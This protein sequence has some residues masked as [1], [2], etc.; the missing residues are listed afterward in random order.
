MTVDTVVATR[1]KRRWGARSFA[2]L[3]IFLIAALLTPIALVGHWGHRTVVDSERYIDT[4][5]PL[6]SNP[7]VQ[8][9]IST[10]ITDALVTK[11]DTANTVDELLNRLFPNSS[12]NSLLAA[13]IAA[14]VNGLIGELVTRFVAS[15]QFAAVW[16]ALNETAQRGLVALLEGREEG[17]I[18]LQGDEVVLD[19]STALGSIQQFLIDN[20]ITAAANISLP[21][22]QRQ[23][24]LVEAPALAQIRF[25]YSLTSP[26]LQ[27]LPLL[28][29]ALFALSIALARRRARL[30][31]A[32]GIFLVAC[33]GLLSMALSSGEESF[34]NQLE[35][36]AFAPASEVF[37]STLLAYLI[38]GLK[39]IF[40]LGLVAI[41]AGWFGG[42]TSV[43]VKVR[44]HIVK[45]LDEL[46]DR[47]EGM[48]DFRRMIGQHAHWIRWAI[49]L[50]VGL[51][52]LGSDLA[53]PSTVLWCTAL[54]AGLI[55]A[56]QLLADVPNEIPIELAPAAV[57]EGGLTEE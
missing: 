19:I 30:V 37:W 34:N 11:V 25:I 55:T 46:G 20:G 35:G 44:G 6:I 54:G 32:A 41:V 45:G 33:A 31:V 1:P 10:T 5:G 36:T 43:A 9:G 24:V 56:L 26:I 4:V 12:F 16:I 42:R 23:I 2:A 22:E 27:W 21:D 52:L 51:I 49:Y 8:E 39:A 38:L 3:I 28:V 47:V 7:E 29:A 15:D 40:V 13:P 53:A 50:L 14:G 48:A 57:I 17:P 18:M